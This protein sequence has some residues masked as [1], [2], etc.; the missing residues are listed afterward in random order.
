M[1]DFLST[2]KPLSSL[3]RTRSAAVA[4]MLYLA[5]AL[6]CTQVPLLNYLG[7]EFSVVTALAGSLIGGML[8]IGGVRNV[9]GPGK[10]AVA[11]HREVLD[12]FRSVLLLNILLLGVPCAVMS[13]NA[14]FVKNCSFME[15]LAF[16]ILLPVVSVCF[17]SCL[18][19]FCTVHYRFARTL[20]LL[21]LLATLV[22]A[23]ALGYFTPAIYSYNVFYGYF[24]G[25]SYDEILGISLP[26][27]LFRIVTLTL[28]VLLLWL[29][30]LLLTSSAS[31]D[32]A[33]RKGLRLLGVLLHP[34]RLLFTAAVVLLLGLLYLYRCDLGFETTGGFVRRILGE[35]YRSEHFV[36]YY[37]K[38]SYGEEEIRRIAAFH[39][40]RLSQILSAFGLRQQPPIESYIYPSAEVKRRLIGTGTTNIAKPW[41][42]QIHM[43]QQSL[44][45]TIKHELV[46]V[47]AGQFG[48]P[49]IQ[50]SFSTGM[51]EGLAMAIE[52]DFGNRTL[53]QYAAGMKSSGLA[54]D[55]GSIMTPFGFAAQS[56]SVSYVLAGSFCRYL[57]DTY[58]IRPMADVY[59]SGDYAGAYG[60][61][62]RLLMDEWNVFLDG[63][64][65]TGRDAIDVIFRQ[66]AIFRKVCA[67]VVA[68]RNDEARR[69]FAERDYAGARRLYGQ[70]YR[71]AGGY[72]SLSG[73]LSST[74]RMGEYATVV[75]MLDS[76]RE[77]SERPGQYAA[78]LLFGGDALWAL[79]LTERALEF[80]ERIRKEDIAEN[81][82]EAAT[83]RGIALCDSTVREGFLRYVLSDAHDSVRV[84]LLDSLSAR[85]PDN[86]LVLYVRGRLLARMGRHG[87]AAAALEKLDM[88]KISP[89]LEALRLRTLGASLF[90]LQ[91]YL[92][93]R[94][95]FSLSL[96]AGATEV[97][98]LNVAD[99]IDR[100]EWMVSHGI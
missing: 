14:L 26:L 13:G 15:G 17:A 68:R 93:A 54:P 95:A 7:Y 32:A 100:C 4:A 39:E 51:V 47:V 40:F 21:F 72:E 71:E 81:L 52:W 38:T 19:L 94:R 82:T 42:R 48:L 80:Y 91:R 50:A 31:A 29:S 74:L 59:R 53:H 86:P 9:Y 16:Y 60:K 5:I 27:V 89:A 98:R 62:L 8:T 33:W 70:S 22:Y 37:S 6:V 30:D 90:H 75:G 34:Q 63:I 77:K 57:I 18:G 49:I 64:P 65:P 25:F 69:R 87:D 12:R 41:L 96:S 92:E 45:V 44:D 99:W 46:H 28:G 20:F 76:I 36:L 3:L 79:G 1:T 55:I 11:D 10:A 83:V 67:R 23:G 2:A 56:S 97:A 35:E 66:P 88:T 43:T 61:P 58:G 73:S 78:L 85:S 84:I 24:P